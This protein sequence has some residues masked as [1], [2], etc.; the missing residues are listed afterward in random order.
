[1]TSPSSIA[2]CYAEAEMG[3]SRQPKAAYRLRDYETADFRELWTIDQQ[4][5]APGIA[6]SQR[7]LAWYMNMR[8]AFT[9]VAEDDQEASKNR[10]E[11]RRIVGFVVGQ[12]QPRGLG[13][14][15]TIDVV[16]EVRR[17]GVGSMLLDAAEQRLRQ[18]GCNAIYLETAV[19]NDAA[20]RF[21]KRHGYSV[22]K[23]I[24]RYYLDSIDALMM[25]KPLAK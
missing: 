13:H 7:E 2:S 9:V 17:A 24:P 25:G 19:D 12:K 4:C 20:L 10:E 3:A 5:F 1:V 21:Y 11:Q 15:V 22:V 23:T 6:Y 18:M 16:A 14:V 8:G